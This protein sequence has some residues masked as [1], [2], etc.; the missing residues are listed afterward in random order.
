MLGS[1][2]ALTPLT[3]GVAMGDLSGIAAA[4]VPWWAR[5]RYFPSGP[6]ASLADWEDKTRQL[7]R[8]SLQEDIRSIS[9]TPSWL[10]LFF[11]R[12]QELAPGP[13]PG[14]AGYYPRLE[15]IAHGGVSFAPYRARFAEL[16]AGS[17]AETREVYPASEGFIAIADRTP[18][19]GMRLL[20]DNGVFFELIPVE[21][22]STLMPTRHWLATAELGVDY[23]LVLS[24]CAGLWSYIAGDTVRLVSL[25][26]PRLFLTGRLSYG[27]SAFGEHLIG[28]E[29]E[30]AVSEAAGEIEA[31]ITD[32][33]VGPV[34]AGRG[35]HLYVIEFDR[36]V[37]QQQLT[38][39]C[40]SVD[41]R[42]AA[43][44]ADYADHR[45]GDF[46]MDPPHII[47]VG[48]RAFADWMKAR[49]KLGG[50]NKV[51]RVVADPD[52]LQQLVTSLSARRIG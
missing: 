47:A 5:S 20:A 1:S 24:T 3:H 15:L 22:L 29:I 21:Q 30:R 26:P 2:T 33:T 35:H 37:R 45:R 42:L 16:L 11:E 10:L 49:G 27:L 12:L 28:E 13:G 32:F 23:A 25:H 6:L 17:H 41:R 34:F 44:N 8:Q 38:A 48:P 4:R 43:L 19:D 39:F 46:G 31:N 51:P 7:A 40:Q 14:L 9:G 36:A 52:A 50:Q 18:D